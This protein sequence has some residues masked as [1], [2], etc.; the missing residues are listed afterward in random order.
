[1]E[2]KV[3]D[4]NSFILEANI[5]F[6]NKYNYSKFIY[7]NAKTKST[8]ICPI[9]NEFEQN[10]DKHLQ[11]VYGCP[12]CSV[13]LRKQTVKDRYH[14]RQKPIRKI[15]SLDIFKS[16]IERFLNEGFVI[17]YNTFVNLKTSEVNV[18][19]PNGHKF[20]TKA[21]L[22][23]ISKYG[24]PQCAENNKPRIKTKSYEQFVLD[25]NLVHQNKYQY[26]ISNMDSFV[27][28]R[29]KIK[30][31]CNQ[32]GEFEKSAQKHLSG[33]G[34]FNCR[35]DKL[36]EDRILLGGYSLSY[37]QNNPDKKDFPA[38]LYYVKV[39]ELFKI[40]ITTNLTNRLKSIKSESKENV[41][42]ID[43]FESSLF[44]VYKLEQYL[45]GKFQKY[46]CYKQWS[47][48]LFNIDILSNSRL[49]DYTCH[50]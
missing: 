42:L 40:G 5:K 15:S 7:V 20:V 46:R 41:S 22:L 33:Q 50:I 19:C 31:L 18:D 2:R 30:I 25:A 12:Q 17:T 34:C 16:K 23:M 8:I 10:P 6:A 21:H 4:L 24:C 14:L 37:F 36:I 1:M 11:G 29:S 44:A 48:E 35:I 39:G 32:H 38:T 13:E 3:I 28:R 27:N 9:H 47:T 49:Q 43:T 45:F 26:P